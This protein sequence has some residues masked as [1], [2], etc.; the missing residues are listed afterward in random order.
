MDYFDETMEHIW[1]V[2]RNMG[3]I[4][5]ELEIRGKNHD[6][7]KLNEPEASAFAALTP[8]L[9]QSTYGSDEY[10]GF[11]KELGE[12]LKHHYENNR[13]HPEHFEHGIADMTLVDL[14]EMFC[15]WVAAAKRHADGDIYKSITVNQDRFDIPKT[16]SS[17]FR[18]TA[19]KYFAKEG[20]L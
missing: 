13:H 4:A 3:L 7:S 1:S 2:E 14:V 17:I 5:S 15:D 6:E 12:T 20:W 16:L 18:N 9:K 8:L 11:L 19:E 10:N